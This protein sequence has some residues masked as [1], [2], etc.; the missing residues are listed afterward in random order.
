MKKK[1]LFYSLFLSAALLFSSCNM[2]NMGKGGLIGG[3]GGAA[4]GAGIGALAGGGKGAGI[5]AAIGGVV[6]TT[7]GLLIGKKMDKQKK[8]LQEQIKNAQI[9]EVTD[10]NGLKAIKVTFDSGILFA[11]GKSNLSQ[12][13]KTELSEFASSLINNPETDVAVLGYTDNTGSLAI[14]QKL[15]LERA[16][17]VANYLINS[18]VSPSRVTTKGMAWNDPVASNDTPEGR[19]QNRRVEIYITANQQMIKNAESGNLN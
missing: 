2:T 10:A 7:A 14:N 4:L 8:E 12:T 3:G 18:G 6:G 9:E 1:N 19:A 11:T 13:A 16:Q 5:G 15:S 17:S